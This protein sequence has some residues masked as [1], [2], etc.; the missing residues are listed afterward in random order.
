MAQTLA[1]PDVLQTN[2]TEPQGPERITLRVE[3]SP[4]PRSLLSQGLASQHADTSRDTRWRDGVVQVV[5]SACAHKQAQQWR[6]C[7]TQEPAA[8][9]L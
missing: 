8:V 5:G 1:T 9:L 7:Q 4:R 3:R 6:V 2:H